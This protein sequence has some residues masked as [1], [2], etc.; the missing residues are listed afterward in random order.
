[1]EGVALFMGGGVRRLV[2]GLGFTSLNERVWSFV[3]SVV[4][5][6]KAHT[7]STFESPHMLNESPHKLIAG[8]VRKPCRE[9]IGVSR[10]CENNRCFSRIAGSITYHFSGF[11]TYHFSGFISYY[12]SRIAGGLSSLSWPL[13]RGQEIAKNSQRGG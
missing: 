13:A 6:S 7:C 3:R 12:F 8:S 1:M 9:I 11:M 10:G 5:R 2:W 4:F